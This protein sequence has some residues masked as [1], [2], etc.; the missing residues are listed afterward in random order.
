MYTL[1]TTQ[2][3]EFIVIVSNAMKQGYMQVLVLILSLS[4]LSPKLSRALTGVLI[5]RTGLEAGMIAGTGMS[6]GGVQI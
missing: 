2:K 3:M 6:S 4:H 5:L 1:M